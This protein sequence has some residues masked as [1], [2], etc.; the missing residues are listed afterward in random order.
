[1]S[2]AQDVLP[3]RLTAPDVPSHLEPGE[4]LQPLG[5]HLRCIWTQL[6]E[7]TDAS[8]AD[9][10]ESRFDRVRADRWSLDHASLVDVDIREPLV[11]HLSAQ[12][13]RWRNVRLTR[14]RVATLDLTEAELDSV[15][16]RGIRIDYL[17]L[18]SA[19]VRDVLLVDCAIGT[20]DLPRAT[21][22]RMRCETSTADEVDPRGMRAEHLDLRGLDAVSFVDPSGLRGAVLTDTQAALHAVAFARSLGI[23]V[24]G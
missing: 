23:R 1:M 13:A 21:V 7:H 15:E 2:A 4:P 18:G 22:A 20:L 12:R 16:L 17:T 11:T 8:R 5:D 3:P 9:I 6:D 24:D 19:R 10:A 14:G